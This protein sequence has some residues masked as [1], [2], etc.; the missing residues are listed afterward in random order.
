MVFPKTNVTCFNDWGPKHF[1]IHHFFWIL[2]QIADL[3][4]TCGV[5][6]K[7]QSFLVG[8]FWPMNLRNEKLLRNVNR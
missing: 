8:F 3:T 2:V 5:T 1:R 6:T 4:R 7:S